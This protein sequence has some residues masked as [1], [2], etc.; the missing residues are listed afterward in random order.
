MTNG[1]LRVRVV[2]L[3][4]TLA[5]GFLPG[6][7]SRR[8]EARVTETQRAADPVRRAS[9]LSVEREL[10]FEKLHVLRIS[11]PSRS[12]RQ[13]RGDRKKGQ[14]PGPGRARHIGLPL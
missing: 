4:P 11:R 8:P 13:R 3:C 1:A 12:G 14:S 9:G 10:D 7:Q 2:G 6:I 5:F